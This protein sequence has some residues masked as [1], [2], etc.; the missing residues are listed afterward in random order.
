MPDIEWEA[1][2]DRLLELTVL[3]SRDMAA[4]LARMGLTESRAHLLWELRTLGPCPQ[5]VLAA[6]M[7]I[8]PRAI[9]ALVDGLE[10]T[11]FVTREP[12]HAD[13]RAT[14]VTFTE[15]GRSS[16]QKLADDHRE[17]ARRLFADM[18]AAAFDRFD[19]GLSQ[20]VTRLRT[21]LG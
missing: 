5:R 19:A 10:E 7:N 17:L 9:T 6:A 11:G 15:H 3:V 18:P 12:S 20:V 16:A 13:R 21:V 8:T 14:L 1:T 4:G 2:L